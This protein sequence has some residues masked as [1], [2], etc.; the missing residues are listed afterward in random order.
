MYDFEFFT[1]TDLGT[2]IQE[3]DIVIEVE[4]VPNPLVE[5]IVGQTAMRGRI[6][7]VV[8]VLRQKSEIPLIEEGEILVTAMTTPD[9]LPAMQRAAAF[10]TDEGGIMCHAAIVAREFGKPCVVGTR[11]ATR[12]LRNGDW[13]EVDGETGIVRI[14]ERGASSDRNTD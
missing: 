10:V 12:A 13:I 9:Y 2:F 6:A 7:G 4:V 1:D 8:R 14:L 5:I 11:I 3:H